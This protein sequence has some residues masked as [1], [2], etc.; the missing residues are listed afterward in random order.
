M[1]GDVAMGGA[2]AP[3]ALTGALSSGSNSRPAGATVR[4]C[5][6]MVPQRRRLSWMECRVAL[7]LLVVWMA[8]GQ[9]GFTLSLQGVLEGGSSCSAA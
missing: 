7:L 3:G 8:L 5:T 2:A 6:R 1:V 9:E 4:V